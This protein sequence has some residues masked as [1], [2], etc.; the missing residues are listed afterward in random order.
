M[1]PFFLEG[2]YISFALEA[3][4]PINI[5]IIDGVPVT[6]IDVMATCYI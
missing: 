1:D 4:V 5:I 2:V 3:Y 6:V